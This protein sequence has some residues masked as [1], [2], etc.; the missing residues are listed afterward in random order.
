V[1]CRPTRAPADR[2]GSVPYRVNPALYRPDAPGFSGDFL[3]DTV[4]TVD[5]SDAREP[6]GGWSVDSVD[7]VGNRSAHELDEA[8]PEDVDVGVDGVGIEEARPLEP[9]PEDPDPSEDELRL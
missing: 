2:G 4:D 8:A 1:A 9:D 3:D 7:G 6:Q 5:T